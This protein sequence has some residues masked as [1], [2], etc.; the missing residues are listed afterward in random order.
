MSKKKKRPLDHTV[1]AILQPDTKAPETG[2]TIPNEEHV[3][4]AKNY[5]DANHK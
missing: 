2:I 5:V 4:N 1:E 3:I